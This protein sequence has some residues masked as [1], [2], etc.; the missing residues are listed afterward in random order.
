MKSMTNQYKY[1]LLHTQEVTHPWNAQTW[2][3]LT[4]EFFSPQCQSSL[5]ITQ[6]CDAQ[7]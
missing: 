2:A 4:L 5:G 7:A 6:P 3:H 1:P